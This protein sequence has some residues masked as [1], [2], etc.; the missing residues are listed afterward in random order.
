MRA[1]SA[2]E[3]LYGRVNPYA[4][5]CLH[6]H[7]IA[8]QGLRSRMWGEFWGVDKPPVRFL[9]TLGDVYAAGSTWSPDTIIARW[10]MPDPGA[11]AAGLATPE[12]VTGFREPMSSAQILHRYPAL[13]LAQEPYDLLLAEPLLHVQPPVPG[14]RL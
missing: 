11:V 4:L 5:E 10:Y 6:A 9:I 13:C 3:N 8:T 14:V 12:V 7:G 1:A 2:R